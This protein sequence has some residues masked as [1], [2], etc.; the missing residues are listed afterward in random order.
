MDYITAVDEM[1]VVSI[2]L[3]IDKYLNNCIFNPLFCFKPFNE[4]TRQVSIIFENQP[5]SFGRFRFYKQIEASLF[6][7]KS[8][9]FS[10]AQLKEITSIF[11]DNNVHLIL[12][13]FVVAMFHVS[14]LYKTFRHFPAFIE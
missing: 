9:G 12:V 6:E 2:R 1:F 10:D 11:T 4:S 3:L 8:M 14:P 7:M 5:M 13:T